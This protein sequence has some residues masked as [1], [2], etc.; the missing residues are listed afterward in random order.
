[1][2]TRI[3]RD[4]NESRELGNELTLSIEFKSNRIKPVAQLK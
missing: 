4:K 3:L 1:M 2:T